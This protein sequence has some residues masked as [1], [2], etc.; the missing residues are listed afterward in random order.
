M[1]THY[2]C[3]VI[4]LCA[5]Q[6]ALFSLFPYDI[7]AQRAKIQEKKTENQE[8]MDF[9]FVL[10]FFALEF[11]HSHPV[12]RLPLTPSLSTLYYILFFSSLLCLLAE[13]FHLIIIVK[14]VFFFKCMSYG[15]C[16]S[17][18]NH[19]KWDNRNMDFFSCGGGFV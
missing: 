8:I 5:L 12:P 13:M 2:P 16:S 3:H 9:K 11:S 4:F 7:R 10:V 17:S 6:R 1:K 15:N 14:K 19:N 18:K